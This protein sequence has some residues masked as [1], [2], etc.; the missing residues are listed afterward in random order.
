MPSISLHHSFGSF[1][2]EHP[3]TRQRTARRMASQAL[4][5]EPAS[6]DAPVVLR[7]LEDIRRHFANN[8]RPYVFISATHFNALEMHR[9]VRNWHN[10]T[11][12]DC[13]D[14]AHPAIQ[15]HADDHSRSFAGIEDV[16]HYLL[17]AGPVQRSL[18]RISASHADPQALFLFFDEALET[19]MQQLGFTVALPRNT[20]VRQVD[21]KVVTTRI[22]NA[23]GVASVPNVLAHIDSYATLRAVA[24]D[25]N[26][27][28]HLVIQLP[29]GD[30]GKTTYFI[31]SETDYADVAPLIE[32]ERTV[33]V[34]RRVR[35]VGT[36]IEACA[37]RWGTFVGPLLKE[38]IG[39][40]ELTPYPGGWCG[41]E[42]HTHAFDATLRRS[43]YR[44]T[45]AIGEALYERGYRGT[46]EI[47][48]LI[49]LDSA[50]VYL[51]ELNPRLTGVTAL[52]NTTRFSHQQ[53]PLLLFHLLEYDPRIEL[54]LDV[55]AFNEAMLADGAQGINSQLILKHTRS[56]L[57]TI[58][59]AP[60]SGIYTRNADGTLQLRRASCL[61]SE[62]SAP[63]EAFVLRIQQAGEL[64]YRGG[65]LAILF[66]ND[67][68]SDES[69]KLN[70]S[71]RAWTAALDAAFVRTPLASTAEPPDAFANIKGSSHTTE[72]DA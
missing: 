29:Y 7:S 44:K 1:L 59:Q 65:D 45:R 40:P 42:N 3:T 18:R 5:T 26:L 52:T 27:G 62:A 30:S 56:G 36:A 28:E 55:N 16:N 43:V 4:S 63:D 48:F 57:E 35:C 51:G 67:V 2:P 15:T 31:S 54:R 60:I 9:W 14:G 58:M 10:I 46:F 24:R 22:G 19:R 8:T 37:T 71:G 25:A 64:A 53:L 49:D 69:G 12:L 41:N 39:Q 61:R 23:A 32:A 17:D 20:L 13:F 72:L 21:S 68:L 33:K 11:L 47:D 66:T 50:E 38:L 70:A 34:M 6:P